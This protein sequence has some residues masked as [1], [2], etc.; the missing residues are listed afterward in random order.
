MAALQRA[1][2]TTSPPRPAQPRGRMEDRSSVSVSLSGRR[3][4]R[5]GRP[6]VAGTSQQV[7]HQQHRPGHQHQRRGDP[8][9]WRGTA[10]GRHPSEEQD[11]Q[12]H[13]SR[14]VKELSPRVSRRPHPPPAPHRHSPIV[15]CGSPAAAR[16]PCARLPP[17]RGG[18]V[19]GGRG[20]VR[21]RG[22]PRRYAR[23]GTGGARGNPTG[24]RS[25]GPGPERPPPRRRAARRRSGVTG[26]TARARGPPARAVRPPSA[27]CWGV[28]GRAAPHRSRRAAHR[29]ARHAP[30][31]SRRAA[32]HGR[33]PPGGRPGA[34]PVTAGRPTWRRPSAGAGRRPRGGPAAPGC[35]RA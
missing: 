25:G 23:P 26:P 31:R 29:P 20:A 24:R 34:G 2:F 12:T 3:F 15:R 1:A 30:V 5:P 35:G 18:P 10:T 4:V 21:R 14:A 17:R 22:G 13:P 6:T 11:A 28:T 16:L 8:H 9:P 33:P 27:P 19:R 7:P 32:H